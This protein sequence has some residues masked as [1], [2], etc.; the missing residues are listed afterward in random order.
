MTGQHPQL[1]Q[2]IFAMERSNFGQNH[3]LGPEGSLLIPPLT[4]LP[5][6]GQASSMLDSV[7]RTSL[8]Q[9]SWLECFLKAN[10]NLAEKARLNSQP[11]V[12]DLIEES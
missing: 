7:L 1:M 3:L 9:N 4:V 2:P 11:L 5:G 10:R 8:L 6:I 12:I